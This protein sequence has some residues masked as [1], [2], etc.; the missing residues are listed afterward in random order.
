[1]KI[2]PALAASVAFVLSS[3][4]H[5]ARTLTGNVSL[6]RNGA[7]DAAGEDKGDAGGATEGRRWFIPASVES[8]AV[9]SRA[10]IL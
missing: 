9:T 5:A 7:N 2:A 8:N 1:M 3:S 6:R 4:A 10:S